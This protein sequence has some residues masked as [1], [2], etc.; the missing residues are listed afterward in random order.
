[1]QQFELFCPNDHKIKFTLDWAGRTVPCPRCGEKFT[2]PELNDIRESLGDELDEEM[3]AAFSEAEVKIAERAQKAAAKK[4]LQKKKEQASAQRQTKESSGEKR[5]TSSEHLAESNMISEDATDA[6]DED[7]DI[8]F[9]C[10]N[11]HILSAPLEM[12][13]KP[14][15]CPECGAKYLTPSLDED[16][17]DE[18]VPPPVP[19]G[20]VLPSGVATPP[21]GVSPSAPPTSVGGTG[22]V[23]SLGLMPESGKTAIRVSGKGELFSFLGK[24]NS[25]SSHSDDVPPIFSEPMARIFWMFWQRR[26]ESS[27]LTVHT[28]DGKVFHPN[29]FHME[30]ALPEVAVF[31]VTNPNGSDTIIAVRWSCITHISGKNLLDKP[32]KPEELPETSV[33]E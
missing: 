18:I 7:G 17:D 15:Q 16:E 14:G 30:E 32:V 20:K 2:I 25:R 21:P 6:G 12:Q 22:D 24:G 5:T 4:A 10:P 23:F 28:D 13:G 33:D 8:E 9:R 31:T 3:Q 26:D 11:G 27:I 19:L 1:M 29:E